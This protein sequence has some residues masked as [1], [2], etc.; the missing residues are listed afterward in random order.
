MPDQPTRR[1]LPDSRGSSARAGAWAWAGDRTP[2][3]GVAWDQ[4]IRLIR[5][6]ASLLV[7]AGAGPM[8]M[9]LYVSEAQPFED[10][11]VVLDGARLQLTA[12]SLSGS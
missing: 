9:R 4:D 3:L 10:A 12:Q 2:R 7:L 6:L 8:P 1:G 11:I 5:L